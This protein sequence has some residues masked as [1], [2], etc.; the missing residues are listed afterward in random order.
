MKTSYILYHTAYGGK[1]I[2]VLEVPSRMIRKNKFIRYG[3][4]M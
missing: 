1:L 2:G 3:V 4:S